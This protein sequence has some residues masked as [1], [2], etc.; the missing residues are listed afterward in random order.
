MSFSRAESRRQQ[1][2]REEP[3]VLE[4]RL[5]FVVAFTKFRSPFLQPKILSMIQR[6]CCVRVLFID[7]TLAKTVY[8]TRGKQMEKLTLCIG[9]I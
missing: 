5:L 4:C 1:P 6:I 8:D 9:S 7:D 2:G 3:E